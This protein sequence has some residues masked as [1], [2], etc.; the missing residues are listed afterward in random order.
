MV[1]YTYVCFQEIHKSSIRREMSMGSDHASIPLCLCTKR[2]MYFCYIA[3][4]PFTVTK[5]S[6]TQQELLQ[7]DGVW[8]KNYETLWYTLLQYKHCSRPPGRKFMEPRFHAESWVISG[9]DLRTFQLPQNEMVRKIR[10]RNNFL[11]KLRNMGEL[12]AR[13]TIHLLPKSKYH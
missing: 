5:Q 13:K 12:M 11:A 8:R 1:S 3:E 9:G 4:I 2:W 7:L 6:T 10:I